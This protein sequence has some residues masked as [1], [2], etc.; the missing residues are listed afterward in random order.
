MI[1]EADWKHFKQVKAD[2][3]DICCQQVLDDVRKGIDDP[4]LSNHAKY[5]YLYKLMENSDKR[6][7]NIF[8]YNARS[9]AML[10]LALM[11][12]DGLL[13]AKQISGFSDEL[14]SFINSRD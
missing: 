3:L 12:S 1:S 5:L 9:K 2:A 11:K 7:V 6:I 13:E 8:D 10:Q 14:Q 4:E